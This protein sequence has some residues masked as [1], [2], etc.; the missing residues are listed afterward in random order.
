MAAANV[1][2]FPCFNQAW[3]WPRPSG[4]RRPVCSFTGAEHQM[5]QLRDSVGGCQT[6]VDIISTLRAQNEDIEALGCNHMAPLATVE[7]CAAA[8]DHSGSRV[9]ITGGPSTLSAK[10]VVPPLPF[11]KF[12]Y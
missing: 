3:N 12:Y 6:C 2:Y 9:R 10:K 8:L 1:E 11:Q 7:L 5:D 4:R